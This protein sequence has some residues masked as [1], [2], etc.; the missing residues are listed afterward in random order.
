MGLAMYR[1]GKY[2]DAFVN[3]EKSSHLLKGNPKL[4]YYMGLCVTHYNKQQQQAMQDQ[5]SEVYA[6][7]F[8]YNLPQFERRPHHNQLKR[9]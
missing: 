6:R 5:E 7:K 3:F 4:W 9:I 8:G 1:D 2:F